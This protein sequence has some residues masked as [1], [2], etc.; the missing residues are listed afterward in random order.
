MS[1]VRG[2]VSVI[3]DK[4]AT[5]T[6]QIELPTLEIPEF[7]HP[8]RGSIT[9]AQFDKLMQPLNTTRVAKRA[10]QGKQMSYLE[11]WDVRAHLIR[12]FGFGNFDVEASDPVLVFE[13]EY[14]GRDD[15]AMVEIAYRVTVTLTVRDPE[16]REISRNTECAVGQSNVGADNSTR[17]DAHDNALK[18]AVSDALKR[19]AI[20]WGTQ[21]GLSLYDDG[22]T[23]DVVKGTLVKPEGYESPPVVTTEQ[24]EAALAASLGATPVESGESDDHP[25]AVA[26]QPQSEGTP[27]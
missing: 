4:G 11:S 15:K 24:A 22:S 6:E 23:R 19:C 25:D 8:E 27:A 10:M 26:A 21:F 12:M 5:V 3:T 14:P 20:N 1:A 17:G 7:S 9:S 16:G 2:I 13:R 18:T